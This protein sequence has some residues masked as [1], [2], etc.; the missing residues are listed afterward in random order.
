MLSEFDSL[1][2]HTLGRAEL[3]TLFSWLNVP[4]LRRTCVFCSVEGLM[5][6]E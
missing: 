5:L 6:A 2:S 3:A 4:L 1:R